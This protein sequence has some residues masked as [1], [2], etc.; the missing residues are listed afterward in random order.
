FYSKY[1]C[2]ESLSSTAEI[3]YE[4]LTAMN[5]VINSD[6]A[7]YLYIGL[8]T[9]TGNFS[10]GN[11]TCNSFV[12][13]SKLCPYGI[14]IERINRLF[15]KD[16]SLDSTKFM[17]SIISRARSYFDGKLILLYITSSDLNKYNLTQSASEGIVNYAIDVDSALVGICV[18]EYSD[19]AYKVSMRGKNFN[20]RQICNTFGGGGHINASGCMVSGFLEDVIDKLVRAVGDVL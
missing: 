9:D 4:I 14:D 7:T 20:V 16:K 1:N 3:V 8:C 6:I 10:H 12:V 17:G 18:C 19:N 13:A 15:F 11:T 5:I 2:I